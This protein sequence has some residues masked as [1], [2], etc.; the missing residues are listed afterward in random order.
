MRHF[1][2]ALLLV[3]A[4]AGATEPLGIKGFVL[5]EDLKAAAARAGMRCQD[6][7]RSGQFCYSTESNKPELI[8]TIAGVPAVRVIL[9][10]TEDGKVGS[11]RYAFKHSDFIFVKGAFAQR[12]ELKCVDS[13]VQ[14]RM[15]AVFDQT[16]CAYAEQ[17]GKLLLRRRT[18]DLTQG[19]VEARSAQYEKDVQRLI[20]KRKAEGKKDT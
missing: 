11:I 14:N 13:T 17:D 1:P 2:L 9:S 5:G 19:E 16:E 18:S 4:A 10:G 6:S 15:G 12:Y 7:P 20:E 8:A 3:C